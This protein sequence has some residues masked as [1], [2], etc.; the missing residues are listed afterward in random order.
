[1][2]PEIVKRIIPLISKPLAH[3]FNLSLSTGVFPAA[4]KVA[5]VI[6]VFK[7]DDPHVFSNYRPISLLP[8]FSKILER[9]IY[10]RLSQ[11]A[12]N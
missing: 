7:K 2:S 8:C 5:K 6:P 1:M 11:V 4:L 12:F 10:N 3:I 9:L